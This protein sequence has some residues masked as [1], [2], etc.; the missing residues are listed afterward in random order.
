MVE[1]SRLPVRDLLDE[2]LAGLLQRP[3]RSVLTMVGTVLGIGAMVIVLGLTS[4]AGGQIDRRFTELAA[5]EVVVEDVGA[6]PVSR[7]MSFPAD[8]AARVGR[9][10]GV[11]AGG[12]FWPL[13]LRDPTV[14]GA[15]GLA[16]DGAGLGL[17]AADP[18][19]LTAMRPTMVTGRTYDSFHQNRQERVAILGSAAASRLGIGSLDLYPAVFVNGVPYTVIG[20]VGE[21][22]RHPEFLLGVV[23]PSSSAMRDFGPPIDQPASMIVETRLGASNVVAAQLP[24]ALRPEAPDRFRAI[25]PPDP[26]SLRSG[27]TEDLNALFLFLAAISLVIGAV[28]IANTTFVG[29]IERTAEI[30]LRRSFGARPRHVAAQFLA[31]SAVLGTLG[32]LV[33]TS[34]GVGTVILIAI[35]NDWTAILHPLTVGPAPFVGTVVGLAAGLYPALR[36]ARIEP[37]DALRR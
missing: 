28:G 12:V 27:V 35:L 14:T 4:T 2:A 6:D 16:A 1:R 15:P 11:V 9:I 19:A 20:I 5:T 37:A 33:G 24:V 23:L 21:L 8:A 29:V 10:D 26:Q 22:A 13:P 34:L 17:Y 25:A 18:Q 32:G 3:G 7:E 30:G 31:E 36:A